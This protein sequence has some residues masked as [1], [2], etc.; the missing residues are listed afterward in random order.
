MR[1]VLTCCASVIVAVGMA[2]P[3][4][5]LIS[6][7]IEGSSNNKY[8]ELYNGTAAAIN[9]ANYQLRL[10]NNGAAAPSTTVALT[11]S[12]AAGSTIV[13]KNAAATVYAGAAT[14]STICAFNG[15]DVVAL[16][17]IAPAGFVDIVG[18]IGCDPG[19]GGWTSGVHST[20]NRTLVRNF[21]VCRGVTVDPATVCPFPTLTTEW[22]S[23]NI[24]DVSNLGTHLTDCTPVATFSTATS[25]NA[26]GIGTVAVNLTITPATVSGG[27]IV[28]TVG[29]TAVYTTDYT[30]TPAVSGTDITVPVAA[31]ATTA[32]FN[33][34]LVQ[35]ALDEGNE[36]ITF[37][38]TTT[39][40]DIVLGAAVT[41]TATILDDDG[42]PQIN[43]TTLS[44]TNSE[45]TACAGC[46]VFSLNIS[47]PAAVA[48]NVT[49]SISPGTGATC[50]GL[51]PDY[52][53]QGV[54]CGVFTFTVPIAVGATSLSF[55]VSHYDDPSAI[56]PTESVTFT[57][58][59]TPWGVG[60]VGATNTATLYIGD[61]NSPPTVLTPGDIAI[62]GVNA[63][64]AG[65]PGGSSG[66]DFISFFCFQTIQTG[67]TIM[68]T[69]NGYERCGL[70]GRW[71]NSE[72]TVTMTRTGVAIPAGQV[73]TYRLA[74]TAGPGNVIGV[75]PDAG[76]TCTP[77]PGSVNALNMLNTGD[78]IFFMQ[79]GT[80][81]N[82]T[83]GSHDALYTG[84]I[85][86]A[87]STVGSPNSWSQN[88]TTQRSNLPPGMSCFSMAPTASSDF[89]K[90]TGSRAAKSQR[91]WI[92]AIDNTA[93]WSSYGNCAGY[94]SA[95]PNWLT[96]PPLP[97]IAGGFT[98][99]LW[100]G[101]TSA[102]WFDCKNWDDAQVPVATTNVRIDET[103]VNHCIV[104]LTAGS[105][106]VC[107]SIVQ[108]NSGTAKNLT[109]QNNSGL[110]VGGP[111]TV[112]RT[113]AGGAVS[114]TVA[115]N[116]TPNTLTAT[117]F[118]VQGTAAN[119]AFL[120]NEGP[121][122]LVTFSGNLAIGTG[123]AVDLRGAVA[124]GTIYVGGN[125]SNAGPTE[126]TL[127]ETFGRLV[128]N[129]TGAQS[130]STT[131]G[132]QDIFYD[133][134]V[135]KP[136]GSLTLNSPV[137]V[138][139]VLDLTSGLINTSNPAGLLTMLAG[140]SAINATDAS[141]VNGPMEKIGYTDFSF[142]I[143]KGTSLRPAG[144]RNIV[145]NFGSVRRHLAEYF[146]VSAYSWGIAR[147]A[148]LHHVSYCEYWLIDEVGTIVSGTPSV[149]I[150]L[151]WRAPNSC[152]VDNLAE[153]RVARWDDAATPAPGIW[154]D[155]GNGGTSGTFLGGTISTATGQNLG[156][157]FN[158]NDITAWTLAS[159]TQNNPLPITLVEFTAKP[160]GNAVRLDWSTASEYENALF[161]IER[162]QYGIDFEHVLDVPG[163][164]FSNV[165]LNYTEVDRDPYGGLSYYRLRQT[166]LDGTFSYS[167]AVPVV[168]G[169]LAERPL[170]VFG[171]SD[172][173]TAVHGFPSGSRYALLDMTG[174]I[175][176]EGST[177]MD[178]RTEFN[179][180][181]LSPG[182]YAVRLVNGDRS[183]STRFVY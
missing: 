128:F 65:C 154:R 36:N 176:A 51:E 20:V 97:I 12:L 159:T 146:P 67:T 21:N 151:T 156:T 163:S 47:P 84:N 137:A 94:N 75:A 180:S 48:G 165:L 11:G 62:V 76:W 59:N 169:G 120:R 162:S 143:G 177:T 28:I 26:E 24:D 61:N 147:E 102:D 42:P 130:I 54:A 91:D 68:I 23:M 179:V 178:N 121:N 134:T 99:G 14:N 138:R 38:I 74:N 35:D 131:G 60:G 16:Y 2:Q 52:Q 90:Y 103:A 157:D 50:G 167:P 144:V 136:G 182:A 66:E 135:N 108:T 32:S 78:Q 142:P 46:N 80:W 9:L 114:L 122:N 141:F 140:S 44:I 37:A 70:A 125:Y 101:T 106:A 172:V 18:N 175:I 1:K 181:G 13:Y 71:G 88:C 116:A 89:N 171:N 83:V 111:I 93:N 117:N 183:E 81:T 148:T 173:I 161:T 170:I 72:G 109:V 53:V 174:R 8:I 29:G 168:F 113:S 57:I 79:G 133:L 158:T 153:L 34:T 119:E 31:G 123:G 100:R 5:L 64:N 160:E 132:F 118:T 92:I 63:N 105:S 115:T 107:A 69:D 110:A 73:I 77:A 22:A 56:E 149:I 85:L 155:R 152:G 112:Q 166:D 145:P 17:K 104:G 10:Y 95:L 98:P 4:D 58:T 49:F 82:G 30:T 124:G 43:F 6:E 127:D 41:H 3:T 15:N 39:T 25:L 33:L 19:A 126:A 87:F 96:E 27:N 129:G 40:G 86:Y 45:N 7:Y 150:D 139:N 164:M 55:N